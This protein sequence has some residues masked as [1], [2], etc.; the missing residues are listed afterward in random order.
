MGNS[1]T[2]VAPAPTPEQEPFLRKPIK[3]DGLLILFLINLAMLLTL[4]LSIAVDQQAMRLFTY[5]WTG[6]LTGMEEGFN[7]TASA[8]R[9]KNAFLDNTNSSPQKLGELLD[10]AYE[11]AG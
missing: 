4:I 6:R 3:R 10:D 5:K 11:W 1:N 8:E 9:I 7:M 2:T